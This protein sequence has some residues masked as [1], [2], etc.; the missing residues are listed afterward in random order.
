VE[1]AGL[2]DQGSEHLGPADVDPCR[3]HGEPSIGVVSV[4]TADLKQDRSGDDISY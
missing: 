1:T 3:Q 2:V 4:G